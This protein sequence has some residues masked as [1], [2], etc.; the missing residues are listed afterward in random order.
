MY[1][2]ATVI[3][4]LTL[5]VVALPTGFYRGLKR[6]GYDDQFAFRRA[7]IVGIVLLG[8][9]AIVGWLGSIEFF[10]ATPGGVG[11]LPVAILTPFAV[12][13]IW[14]RRDRAAKDA[15][16]HVENWEWIGLQVLRAAGG[17]FLILWSLGMVPGAFALPAGIGDVTVGV[18][19]AV[20]A[21]GLFFRSERYRRAGIF[22]NIFGITDFVIAVSTGFLTSPG[23][24]Q[25]LSLE[26]PNQLI[27]VLPL[28]FI[29]GFFVP[30]FLMC[31]FFS[32]KKLQA[33]VVS[34]DGIRA[35][36]R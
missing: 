1:L 34:S 19:A 2:L 4:I 7:A 30:L 26:K 35:A 32:L 20:I 11:T 31:H 6:A 17:M 14:L 23:K 25:L 13:S 24:F 12:V 27:S 8:W 5:T 29:P 33:E 22:W 16:D 15:I 3:V 36:Q 10:R 28:V 21:R 18:A 9:I